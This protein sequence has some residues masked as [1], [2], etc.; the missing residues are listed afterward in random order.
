MSRLLL[1]RERRS[2]RRGEPAVAADDQA[3]DGRSVSASFDAKPA[4]RALAGTAKARGLE[5]GFGR[6]KKS[7]R[8]ATMKGL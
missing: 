4:T 8:F 1:I 2:L 6:L 7:W 3:A 5:S